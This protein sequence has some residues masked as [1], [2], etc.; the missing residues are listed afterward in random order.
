MEPS[1]V[2]MKRSNLE[3]LQEAG[4]IEGAEGFPDADRKIIESLSEEEVTGLISAT[5]SVGK[6]F[7]NKY[8]CKKEGSPVGIVF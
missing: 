1:E 2:R 4:L 5:K 3:R 6:E 7:L 8:A